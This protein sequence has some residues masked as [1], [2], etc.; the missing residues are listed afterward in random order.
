MGHL[1]RRMPRWSDVSQFVAPAL[2]GATGGALGRLR[3]TADF[4]RLAARRTP[5]AVFEYVSGG[6]E[7]EIALRR[8]RQAF[9][10]VEFRPRVLV[11]VAHVDTR[12]T[13]LGREVAF[14]VVLGPTGFTRMM[15]VEGEPAVARPAACA[16]V[17]YT[18]STMGTTSIEDLAAQA[19]GGEHWFQLYLWRDRGRSQDLLDRARASGF[20]TLVLTVDV[21]VAGAR[22]R[23]AYNGLT[24]PPRLTPRT[25]LDMGRHPRWVFDALTTQPL[26]FASLG[27][28][29]TL[30]Q[31]INTVF[32]PSATLDDIGWLRSRWDGPVVVKGLQ[33]VDDAKAAVAAGADAIVVSNHGG[34]QLDRAPTPLRLLPEVADALGDHAEVYLD[35]GVRCGADVAAAVALGA[36]AVFV[37]RPYLYALMAAGEA[38]VDRLLALFREDYVRT[39]RLLGVT[40]T[41]QLDRDLVRLLP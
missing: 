26:S 35:G 18:L 7:R 38:G 41:A 39:L 23:D 13:V 21:P 5:R 16:G 1:Q 8:G 4:E 17:P 29:D 3:T 28:S 12:T 27:T 10:T 2:K 11:D 19:P 14:P 32:D 37:A 30:E 40:S 36:R 20:R 34:R 33:R 9:E 31:V 15:R 6:A 25:L 24:I 22:L